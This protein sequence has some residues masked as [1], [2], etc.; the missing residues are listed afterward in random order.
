MLTSV[1]YIRL[2][3]IHA[4]LS[5]STAIEIIWLF[6]EEPTAIGRNTDIPP[7]QYIVSTTKLIGVGYTLHRAKRLVIIDPEWMD[8]DHEQAKKRINRIGQTEKTFTY[9]L[10]CVGSEVEETIYDRQN[11]RTHLVRQALDPDNFAQDTYTRGV[12][13][14]TDDDD[15]MLEE[16][17]CAEGSSSMYEA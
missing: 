1:K 16:A 11:R 3:L 15:D 17:D 9:A 7:P 10:R 4:G 5:K 12:G 13:N 2:V 6:Q 8:R 14:D